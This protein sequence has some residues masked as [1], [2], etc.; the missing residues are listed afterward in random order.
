MNFP[1]CAESLLGCR[2]SDNLTVDIIEPNTPFLIGGPLAFSPEWEYQQDKFK[3]RERALQKE[4]HHRMIRLGVQGIHWDYYVSFK[5]KMVAKI[6][7][8]SHWRMFF[9]YVFLLL[10]Y[11]GELLR[12]ASI[13][14]A[15]PINSSPRAFWPPPWV[16]LFHKLYT[17]QCYGYLCDKSFNVLTNSHLT[18]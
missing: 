2:K 6:D 17:A 4:K 3:R 9:L 14:G 1:P 18:V 15:L 16:L 10:W 5:C 8:L 13:D 12:G 7:K 11:W